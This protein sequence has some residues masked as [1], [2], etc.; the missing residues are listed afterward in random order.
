MV[1]QPS[2]PSNH[3]T[4]ILIAVT[5]RHYLH[6]NKVTNDS[7]TDNDKPFVAERVLTDIFWELTVV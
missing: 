2:R 5:N 1:Q 6:L 3:A 7:G 4:L